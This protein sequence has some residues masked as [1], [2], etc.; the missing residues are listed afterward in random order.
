MECSLHNDS[1]NFHKCPSSGLYSDIKLPINFRSMNNALRFE[2][3]W[4]F[5][6][7]LSLNKVIEVDKDFRCLRSQSQTIFLNSAKLYSPFHIFLY[8][9]HPSLHPMSPF[10]NK[11][12]KIL[13]KLT[14][15]LKFFP[16]KTF[17]RHAGDG[18]G[19]A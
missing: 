14:F 10:S 12:K 8:F 1:S 2:S 16:L 13:V 7:L 3:F 17:A 15:L 11:N 19:R 18:G 4:N 6:L 9:E 5:H